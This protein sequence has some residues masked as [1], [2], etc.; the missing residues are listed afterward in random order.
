M[1]YNF[2]ELVD[3]PRVQRLTD[4]FFNV[5]G[6]VT[7]LLTRDG[8]IL[9]RSGWQDICLRFHRANP[10]T[11]QRCLES[12]THIANNIES[13]YKYSLYQCK[14]GLID[15][16]VP[17]IVEEEHVATF[18]TGQFLFKPPD[19]DFFRKQAR[20][21]GF[22]EAEYLSCVAKIP[23]MD[24]ARLQPFLEY[25][26]EFAELLSDMGVRHFKQRVIEEQLRSSEARMN[27][28]Q[29]IAHLG[30][31]ELE[32]ADNK[33]YWSDEAYR[34]FGVQP[35][36][37]DAT[38]EAFL[39]RVH[40]D[41]RAAVDE[42]YSG[43]LREGRDAYELEHRVV[44]KSDG[45]IRIVHE[46]CE[47]VRDESG[48]VVRSVGMV[49]DITER[50]KVEETLKDS[51]HRYRSLF[52][53]ML[54]GYAHCRMIF[55]GDRPI[56]VI[57]LD[58]NHSFET[59]TGLKN[60][61]G[62][63][64]SDV[65]PGIWDNDPGLLHIYA[66]VAL[67]GTP[68]RFER[69]VGS[70]GMW[71]SIS[72]YSPRKEYF[73]A[74]FDVI[75]ERK[76]TEEALRNAHDELET[77]VQ[78]RT[79]E[80]ER[81][82][83]DLKAEVEERK[84]TEEFIKAARDLSMALSST[85]DLAHA[86]QL[87]VDTAVF[88]SG[89]DIAGIY[90]VD[91]NSG[92]VDLAVHRNLPPELLSAFSHYNKDTV[93]AQMVRARKPIYAIFQ[94]L[95]IPDP[96]H[97]LRGTAI[98]PICH[99]GIAV[100]CLNLA[101]LVSD[102]IDP[103][104]RMALETVALQVGGALIRIQMEEER[105][106]LATAVEHAAEAVIIVDSSW[107]IQYVN[108]AF[109]AMTG[110]S[111]EESVRKELS[112]LRPDNADHNKYE[113]ARHRVKTGVP[114]VSR[115]VHRKKDGSSFTVDS[116][117]FPLMDHDGKI[118]GYVLL[119][120][121]ISDSL[122]LE[123]RLRQSQKMEAIGT[124]AGGIAHDFNNILAAILGFTEMAI[125]D[126]ADCFPVKRS[127]Q[128]IHKSAI[129]ARDLVKQILAFSRKTNYE[130]IALSLSSI[131]GETVQLLRASIPANIEMKLSITATS[132]TIIAAPT[133]V[134]QILM[135]L[136]TNA[137]LAMEEKG[138]VLEIDLSDIDLMPD[139]SVPESGAMPGEYVQL[140]VKDT[141]AGM[142]PDVMKRAFEPFFT[143]REQGE[144]TGMGLAVVYGIV[145]D[146]KGTITVESEVG[147]GTIFRV[148]LPKVKAD[149]KEDD[150]RPPQIPTGIETILFVDDE[151]ML[152][153][154]AKSILEKL[155]YSV[156][157]V[158][159]PAKAWTLFS[160]DPWRFDIVITD[161]SMPAMSGL[162]LAR[163]LRTMRPDIPII[164]CT[165]H[166][167]TASVEIAQTAGIKNILIKPISRQELATVIRHVL[168]QTRE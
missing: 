99:E 142:T 132:D 123:E 74:V 126:S 39:E 12:D 167:V 97:A 19:L 53:N 112:F 133:E 163:K 104:V 67:T 25:F 101:S 60:V 103:F 106:R 15:A 164:L 54:E 73:V 57:Y 14:N 43:S 27:R 71:F 108:P 116:P 92:D 62:K 83:V 1:R 29:E 127:L 37:F 82:H 115:L 135:N 156:V 38:Y 30:S 75:T 109:T 76:R 125:D 63:K 94:D 21:F 7:A 117:V 9:T 154:W 150:T 96:T 48:T 85:S 161:Q 61:V 52:E 59:L 113:A 24:E 105:K 33:L 120:R 159:D 122:E 107:H 149:V 47:H 84:R 77:R 136:A 157:S 40:P 121:D 165:G 145:N 36:E 80:L 129:R 26:A 148:L 18:F 128:N 86:L 28:T 78:K 66:R 162:D 90:L 100:A 6:I 137:S 89:M 124:L 65:I 2:S 138:G 95:G 23:I 134:Q 155:G 91:R 114:F 8:T 70:L 93:N 87:C 22:D 69:Y 20:E 131:V 42:A 5:T 4:L 143:T 152:V 151:E 35:Q 140:K 64:A 44:R 72:V 102:E 13:G 144:G 146:L 10:D 46:K 55:D 79:A 110:Y 130:R 17:I 41:D 11:R 139:M 49:H 16:A 58:I 32:V 81:V 68:E 166:D 147:T 31:W 119:W 118:S 111:R 160:S 168:D 34:I 88:V 56:D 51:E 141:G 98:L 50:K 3:I 45:E 158:T 153:E